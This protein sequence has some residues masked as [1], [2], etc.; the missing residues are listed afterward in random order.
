MARSTRRASGGAAAAAKSDD[1]EAVAGKG[2]ARRRRLQ[3][4]D[5]DPFSRQ[6]SELIRGVLHTGTHRL[7]PGLR[8]NGLVQF[9]QIRRR[10]AARTP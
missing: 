2:G 10:T 7:R 1:D 8:P 6:G 5:D 4:D 9:P 3:S